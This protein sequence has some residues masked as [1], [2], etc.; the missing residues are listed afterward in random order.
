MKNAVFW[1]IKPSS[2]LTGDILPLCYRAQP[3]TAC[4]PQLYRYNMKWFC[5]ILT[6]EGWSDG[7]VEKAA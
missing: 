2:N 6:K 7:R 1:D 4:M 3:V 5:G